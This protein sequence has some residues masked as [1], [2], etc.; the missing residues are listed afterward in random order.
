MA[1]QLRLLNLT[2]TR[3]EQLD[4]D[5]H[6]PEGPLSLGATAI[7]GGAAVSIG[8]LDPE[9]VD[10]RLRLGLSAGVGFEVRIHPGTQDLDEDG[11]GE[12][13]IGADFLIFSFDV[14]GED[15]TSLIFGQPTTVDP[16]WLR[17]LYQGR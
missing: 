11:R 1:L 4:P 7:V 14:Y 3:L 16:S 13:G 8:D 2:P 5:W 12:V 9:Q 15:L 10:T 17:K 6:P